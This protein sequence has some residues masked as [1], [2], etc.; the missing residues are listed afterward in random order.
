MTTDIST[1]KFVVIPGWMVQPLWPT[2][3]RGDP[4]FK[5]LHTAQSRSKEKYLNPWKFIVKCTSCIVKITRIASLQHFTIH[6]LTSFT[7]ATTRRVPYICIL[8]V[9]NWSTHL[10]KY[11]WIYTTMNILH[12]YES[13]WNCSALFITYKQLLLMSWWL[14]KYYTYAGLGKLC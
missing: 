14:E 11:I 12:H 3:T 8:V 9:N 1:Y 4:E 7:T 10:G 6:T 5:I 2:I 13:I